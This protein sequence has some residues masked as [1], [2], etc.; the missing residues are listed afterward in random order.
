M[1]KNTPALVRLEQEIQFAKDRILMMAKSNEETRAGAA[2]LVLQK[3]ALQTEFNNLMKLY[4]KEIEKFTT[5][6]RKVYDLEWRVKT[7]AKVISRL[8]KKLK[9]A[10]K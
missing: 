8:R 4:V 7:Q 1:S 6:R 10:R 9:E 2:K 3:D 5:E